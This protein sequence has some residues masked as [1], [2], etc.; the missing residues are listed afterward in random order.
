MNLTPRL[1]TVLLVVNLVILA[2][3]LAGIAVLR[4]YESALVRQTESALIAQG[5]FVA[6]AYKAALARALRVRSDRAGSMAEYGTPMAPQW[7]QQQ[8]RPAQWRPRPA[9]LDL[10][11]DEIRPRPPEPAAASIAPDALDVGH[12]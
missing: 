9:K 10:A 5:A 11:I 6:A 7:A 12:I 8:Q 2:L 1:R 4:L 3:P